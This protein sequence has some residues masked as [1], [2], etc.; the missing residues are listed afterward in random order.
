MISYLIN[1]LALILFFLARNNQVRILCYSDYDI[2]DNS[3]NISLPEG[4]I[5]LTPAEDYWE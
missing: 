4:V 1:G 5:P 2:V 3:S